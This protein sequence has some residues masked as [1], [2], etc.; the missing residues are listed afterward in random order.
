MKETIAVVLAFAVGALCGR[1]QIP[2]P[3]PPHW[4]GVLLIVA[5][6]AGYMVCKK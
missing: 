6:W 3:A 5:I 2:L 4:L 1:F